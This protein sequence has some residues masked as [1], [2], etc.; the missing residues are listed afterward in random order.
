MAV[1]LIILKI[2]LIIV[3]VLLGIILLV[4]AM[5]VGADVSFIDGKL[6]Y[7]VRASFI[8][9]M[10]SDGGGIIGLVKK[11]K[12]KRKKKPEKPPK[13]KKPKKQKKKKSVVN[14]D[15]YLDDFDFDTDDD[16]QR[17]LL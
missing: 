6:T 4:L 11:L 8:N 14:D 12:A 3:L 15:D 9:I 7:R 2:L 1:L 17:N 5:P 10:D 16:G 13:V